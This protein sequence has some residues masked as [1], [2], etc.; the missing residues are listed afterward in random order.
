MVVHLP[1]FMRRPTATRKCA[2]LITSR[3]SGNEPS[4]R[5]VL[6]RNKTGPDRKGG[7]WRSVSKMVPKLLPW[8]WLS[9]L[10]TSFL[11][12]HLVL[13]T[14]SLRSWWVQK[15]TIIRSL[16][17]K[18][19]FNGNQELLTAYMNTLLYWANHKTSQKYYKVIHKHTILIVLVTIPKI[20]YAFCVVNDV[21]V[22]Q[23]EC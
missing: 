17:S 12:T 15:L 7:K 8:R 5:S 9:W 6:G 4:L 19:K 2:G 23:E 22:H 21:P 20:F 14:M 11:L 13:M 3:C 10:P 16:S 18:I 1:R